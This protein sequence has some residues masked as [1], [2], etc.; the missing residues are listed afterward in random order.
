MLRVGLL[1]P[2]SNTVMER[3]LH[4]GLAAF[5]DVHTA[6][7][8]LSDVTPEAEQVMLDREAL[9]AA[10]RVA[11]VRPD[12]VVFGCT[13]ASS[14]HGAAYDEAFRTHLAETVGVEV[15][16]VLSSVLAELEGRGS[17]ALFTPY[18]DA[19]TSSI[20]AS[21]E[22]AGIPIASS[23]GLGLG[24]NLQIG[25]LPPEQVVEEV[26][27]MDLRGAAM[28]F[29]SCTNLRAYEAVGALQDRTGLPVVTSNQAVVSQLRSLAG[30]PTHTPR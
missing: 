26:G 14:L 18:V 21:L 13:S 25:S 3:D 27:R 28:L 19:L 29:C 20:A 17:V 30:L 6:R 7:M 10:E 15:L 9:P 24:D 8:R 16:G 12:V 23:S 11:D 5:A 1:V 4:R 2:S 22:A